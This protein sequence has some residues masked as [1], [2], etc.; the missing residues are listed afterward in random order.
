MTAKEALEQ[1]EPMNV[2]DVF[3]VRPMD[4]TNEKF[5]I[6]VGNRLASTTIYNSREEA[7][8]AIENKDWNLIATLICEI[9]PRITSKTEEQ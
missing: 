5:I 4:E 2:Q 1:S 3:K 7:E 8:R 9:A 6:S